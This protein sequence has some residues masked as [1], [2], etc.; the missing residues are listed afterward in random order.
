MD[1]IAYRLDRVWIGERMDQLHY[2]KLDQYL[3][4][5]I[6]KPDKNHRVLTILKQR[7][8]TSISN[9]RMQHF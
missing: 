7:V 5:D 3:A 9:R 1:Q 2:Q 8:T 6:G 4:V